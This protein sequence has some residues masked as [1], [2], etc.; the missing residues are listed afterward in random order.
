MD[1][2]METSCPTVSVPGLLFLYQWASQRFFGA[3]WD[4][5]SFANGLLRMPLRKGAWGK[6]QRKL[7]KGVDPD[8]PKKPGSV[9]FFQSGMV[10]GLDLVQLSAC[11]WERLTVLSPAEMCA[12]AGRR[13]L[14]WA[15]V[16]PITP[17]STTT[18]DPRGIYGAQLSLYYREKPLNFHFN[19]TVKLGSLSL[20][21][22]S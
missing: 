3:E 20:K 6:H 8:K 19:V 18:G 13:E 2:G 15:P 5:D 10:Y 16:I 22:L 11:P 21:I 17:F 4:R 9:L 1:S 12:A 14:G 7:K